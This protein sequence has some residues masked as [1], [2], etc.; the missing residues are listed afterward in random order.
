MLRNYVI[1]IL[2]I[3]CVCKFRIKAA[4]FVMKWSSIYAESAIRLCVQWPNLV[5]V[6][7]V[8]KTRVKLHTPVHLWC[9][10]RWST[11]M[12]CLSFVYAGSQL[13]FQHAH[14][15]GKRVTQA[16]CTHTYVRVCVC[17]WI[18]SLINRMRGLIYSVKFF[19]TSDHGCACSSA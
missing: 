14:T 8:G 6:N 13:C 1:L 5:T 4:V 17:M 15:H 2:K 18:G 3:K 19:S 7:H 9:V 10:S 11:I 12:C 16:K